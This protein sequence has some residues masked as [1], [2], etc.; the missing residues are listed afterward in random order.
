MAKYKIEFDKEACIGALSC[1]AAAPNFWPRSNDGKV[2]LKGSIYNKNTKKWE[3]IV[4]VKD[5]EIN[6]EAEEVCPVFV[7]KISKIED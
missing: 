6:K 2:D 1:Y 5:I 4:G 3:L 7:I